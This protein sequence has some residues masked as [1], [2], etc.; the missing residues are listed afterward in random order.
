S[1]RCIDHCQ[2]L[3]RGRSN[4]T[5]M[6]N[7]GTH[8]GGVREASVDLG[9]SYDVFVHIEPQVIA[10]YL[11]EIFRVLR[12]DGKAVLHHAGR[13]HAFL[14]LR[15][16]RR[17][18]QRGNRLYNY[19]TIKDFGDDDGWRSNVSRALVRKLAKKQ[20]LTVERQLNRWG[21]HLEFG[22]PRFRDAISVLR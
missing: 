7:D 19:L 10:G 15:F 13:R 1:P 21:R 18:G 9:W 8:L 5:F 20:G 2:A 4:V 12:A 6:V 22:V 16:L 3:F 17:S 14:P 11:G